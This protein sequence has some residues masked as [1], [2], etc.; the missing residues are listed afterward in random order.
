MDESQASGST[1]SGDGNTV[2]RCSLKGCTIS[3]SSVKRCDLN[4]SVLSNV[5]YASRSTAKNSNFEHVALL[6]RSE[7]ADSV[8]KGR[9]SVNRSTLSKAVI[10][11]QSDLKR[12]TITGTTIV[13]SHIDRASLTDCD[14]IECVVSRSDFRGMILKYGFWKKGVLVG[15]IGD[16]EP[17]AI[18]M[19]AAGVGRSVPAPVGIPAV[20]QLDSKA[21][22]RLADHPS[23]YFI[24]SD[25]SIDGDDD[26][27]DCHDLPPPYKA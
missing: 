9:I 7:I 3:D 13:K 11:D 15:R 14:V 19:D 5:E 12:C 10:I 23:A 17:V 26:S 22:N 4:D 24:D 20:P 16:H 27:D 8:L 21:A 25:V 2:M 1:L 6:K 18:K